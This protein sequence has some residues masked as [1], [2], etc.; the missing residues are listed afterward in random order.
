MT[1]HTTKSLLINEERVRCQGFGPAARREEGEYPWWIFDRR[2]TPPPGQRPATLRAAFRRPSGGVA[3]Q[4]QGAAAML[5]GA[6]AEALAP[7]KTPAGKPRTPSS[8]INR[9]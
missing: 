4:S 2:A 9:L 3:P 7:C 8:F 6:R 1:P 5:C